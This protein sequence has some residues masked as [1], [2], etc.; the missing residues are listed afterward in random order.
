MMHCTS[1]QAPFSPI[2]S[3]PP[4]Y[5]TGC[6]LIKHARHMAQC[7]ASVLTLPPA[8]YTLSQIS[9]WLPLL[10]TMDLCLNIILL[11]MTA[12]LTPLTHTPFV[13]LPSTFFSIAHTVICDTI[14]VLY[15]LSFPH[16]KMA[17]IFVF[18]VLLYPWYLNLFLN[19][20]RHLKIIC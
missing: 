1:H 5:T 4:R 14:L 11:I 8:Y 12:S 7:Q 3:F 16:Q 17:E 2:Y 6:L 9:P 18:F 20:S 19:G 10:T 15:Y 13:S